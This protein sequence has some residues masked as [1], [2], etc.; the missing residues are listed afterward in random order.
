MEFIDGIDASD[1]DDAE[2]ERNMDCRVLEKCLEENGTTN[3]LATPIKSNKTVTK[4]HIFQ[5]D[6]RMNLTYKDCSSKDE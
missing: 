1:A 2:A 5:Y 4:R 3:A 6:E